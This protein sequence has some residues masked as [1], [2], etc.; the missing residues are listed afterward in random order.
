[1][2]NNRAILIVLDSVGIGGA[3]DAALYGDDGS[4]TLGH[5]IEAANQGKADLKGIRSGPLMLPNLAA[6]GLLDALR[7][8]SGETSAGQSATGTWGVGIESSKGKDTTSGHWEIAGTPVSKDFHYFPNQVPAF[9][10][11]LID[12]IVARFGLPGVV[13]N[14]H[15]SGTQIIEELGAEHVATGKPIFYTSADSVIQIAA[16]ET[17]FG[18]D[19]LYALCAFVR[20]L[21]DPLMVGR[22]IARPFV[23][24]ENGFVR[25]ANRRDFSLPPFDQTLLDE[26]VAAGRHVTGVGKISDIFA[27]RGISESRK[28]TGIQG[29][30]DATLQA[31]RDLPAGGLIFSNI[32]EFDSEFGHRRDVAGYANALETVDGLIPSILRELGPDD[33]LIVTADHGN[34][35]IWAGTDHTRERTPILIAGPDAQPGSVGLRGF[36]DIA[37]TIA[38][39]LGVKTNMQSNSIDWKGNVDVHA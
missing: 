22:V 31:M 6:L 32:V 13:G 28:A 16:H 11:N 14:K 29:T 20:D 9:P 3:D 2:T 19:R 36:A 33:L 26:L 10:G 35:P 39:H 17:H 5:I 1:M 25:S 21:V 8:A 12:D 27:G 23:G 37:A 34:D 38:A 18:L 4:N 24:D 30:V 15:A 7:L